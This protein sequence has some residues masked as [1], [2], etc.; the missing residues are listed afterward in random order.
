MCLSCQKL[1]SAAIN[2]SG[3]LSVLEKP[4]FQLFLSALPFLILSFNSLFQFCF[5]DILMTY[6][7][8]I[9][10]LQIGESV[11]ESSFNVLHDVPRENCKSAW[12]ER[13]R[14]SDIPAQG[15]QQYPGDGLRQRSQALEPTAT[16]NLASLAPLPASWRNLA[17]DL[18]TSATKTMRNSPTDQ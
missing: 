4:I 16:W 2:L 12:E 8:I 3:F 5:R 18:P 14:F 10:V 1:L 7:N 17:V 6:E 13:S 9:F 15:T 11:P